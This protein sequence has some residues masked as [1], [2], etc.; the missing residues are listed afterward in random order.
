MTA[1][2]SPARTNGFYRI[3]YQ[4][5]PAVGYLQVKPPDRRPDQWTERW[6]IMFLLRYGDR[7][8]PVSTT[9]H[10]LPDE[11]VGERIYP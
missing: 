5:E 9:V 11:A 1:A 4:G 10:T 2:T 8:F 7:L 6:S 3:T